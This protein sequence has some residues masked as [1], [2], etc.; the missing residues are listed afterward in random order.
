MRIV[1]RPA[2]LKVLR[3]IQPAKAADIRAAIDRIAAAPF[4]PNNNLRALTGV[5]EGFRVRVGDWRVLYRL[6]READTMDIFRIAPRGGA[7]R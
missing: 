6:D 5:P 3:R 2:A 1:I 7:Y 4:A